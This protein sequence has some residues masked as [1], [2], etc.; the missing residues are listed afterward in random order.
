M[1]EPKSILHTDG[2]AKTICDILKEHGYDTDLSVGHSKFRVDVG[3]INPEHPD[4][5]LLGILL[6]GDSYGSAKTTRDREIAQINVLYG[7][8]WHVM[9]IWTMDWWD[10]R[11]KEISR[12]LNQL[13]Q[14]KNGVPESAELDY[15]VK[16]NITPPIFENPIIE[17]LHALVSTNN[18]PRSYSP[19]KLR[20]DYL[21]SFTDASDADIKS[22]L[23]KVIDHESPI[24][25]GL[26]I[27]RVVQ[28]YGISRAGSNIQMRILVIIFSLPVEITTEN[29]QNYYWNKNMMTS[30]LYRDF[31]WSGEGDSKRDAKDVSVTEAVNALCYALSEQICLSQDDLCREGAKCLGYTRLG[32]MVS[33]LMSQ[34]IISAETTGRIKLDK[35]KKWVLCDER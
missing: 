25:A 19:T 2:I 30:D 13:E 7:F 20:I 31:R 22:K 18:L 11:Q 9:R 33:D 24:S 15:E 5:Y 1:L 10:N 3:V 16:E 17:R 34:A 35:N 26:L 8:G 14:I 23:M 4:T 6:D 21:S 27:R 12:I 28:S 29:G 32:N